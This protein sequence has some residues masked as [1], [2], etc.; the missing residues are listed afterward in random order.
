MVYMLKSHHIKSFNP[1]TPDSGQPMWLVFCFL[2]FIIYVS[3]LLFIFTWFLGNW[4][5][6]YRT[7]DLLLKQEIIT[8]IWSNKFS[9]YVGLFIFVGILQGAYR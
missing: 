4:E 2:F 7:Q 9:W 1:S 6:A 5:T 8:K 3:P